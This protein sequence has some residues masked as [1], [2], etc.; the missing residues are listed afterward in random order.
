MVCRVIINAKFAFNKKYCNA[1]IQDQCKII[2]IFAKKNRNFVFPRMFYL[3]KA[4]MQT[5]ALG[6][7]CNLRKECVDEKNIAFYVLLRIHA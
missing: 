7:K 1:I 5:P 6:F 2:F 4:V 3:N